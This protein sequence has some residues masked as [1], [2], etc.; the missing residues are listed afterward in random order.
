MFIKS[1]LFW[2]KRKLQGG[3]QY[4]SDSVREEGGLAEVKEVLPQYRDWSG[5]S[6]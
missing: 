3:G 2:Q 4:K 5:T 1:T 6:H